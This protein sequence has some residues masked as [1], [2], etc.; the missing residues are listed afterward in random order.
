MHKNGETVAAIYAAFGKGDV[1]AILAHLADDVEWEFG[2]ADSG[3]P[4]YKPRKGKANVPGF[5]ADLAA[6][7]IT[8]FA[9]LAIL[10]DGDYVAVPI[11]LEARVKATGKV[12][13][14][15]EGHLWVFNKQGKVR[16][17]KHWVDTLSHYRAWKGQ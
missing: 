2:G 3:I 17:F 13:K 15:I 16:Q 1:P 5:F 11:D 6:I 10:A 9:P 12:V 4:W 7:E 8:K 14:E